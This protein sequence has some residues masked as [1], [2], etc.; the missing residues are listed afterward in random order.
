MN[1]RLG[2]GGTQVI[3]KYT[4]SPPTPVSDTS[5]VIQ[6]QLLER[7]I[8]GDR[9]AVLECH[10]LKGCNKQNPLPHS[11]SSTMALEYTNAQVESARTN[12]EV[13]AKQVRV[14]MVDHGEWVE[15]V[16][17]PPSQSALLSRCPPLCLHLE[18]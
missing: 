4:K 2:Q 5:L 14:Y 11:S 16:Q 17:P 15:C 13:F 18:G 7:L 12:L 10:A 1:F 6:Q 9:M 3:A 8:D